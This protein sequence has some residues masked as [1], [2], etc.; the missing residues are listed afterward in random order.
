MFHN[1]DYDAVF[2]NALIFD[3]SVVTMPSCPRHGAYNKPDNW[4]ERNR[5]ELEKVKGQ[6]QECIEYVT[7]IQV[8][9]WMIKVSN[10][11]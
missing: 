9:N 4:V 2:D 11:I 8:S 6:L 5:I 7:V 10:C 1:G 3:R